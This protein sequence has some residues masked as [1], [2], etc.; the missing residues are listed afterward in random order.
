MNVASKKPAHSRMNPYFRNSDLQTPVAEVR[1]SAA[2]IYLVEL[3][4]QLD[5]PLSRISTWSIH[6]IIL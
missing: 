6:R 5:I 4:A 3:E 1:C 2:F